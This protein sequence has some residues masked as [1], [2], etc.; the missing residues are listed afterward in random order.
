MQLFLSLHHTL[1]TAFTKFYLRIQSRPLSIHCDKCKRTIPWCWYSWRLRDS[2]EPQENIRCYLEIFKLTITISQEK[3]DT[4]CCD[5]EAVDIDNFG[6]CQCYTVIKQSN[7][8]CA[9][10]QRQITK[11][12][13]L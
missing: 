12:L 4:L 8:S 10:R 3:T 13:N 11:N 5:A 6:K 1:S 7:N 2:C 9:N